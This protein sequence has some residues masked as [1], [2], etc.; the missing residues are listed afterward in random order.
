MIYYNYNTCIAVGESHEDCWF[1]WCQSGRLQGKVRIIKTLWLSQSHDHNNIILF[2]QS[3]P[4]PGS[5]TG[6]CCHTQNFH[7]IIVIIVLSI[8]PA[9]ILTS[10]LVCMAQGWLTSSSY[11][12]GQLPLKCKP[13]IDVV[14][15]MIQP[16]EPICNSHTLGPIVS[17]WS[18]WLLLICWVLQLG[19]WTKWLYN[20]LK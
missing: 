4:L 8:R 13:H 1:L 19:T 20:I 11:Q 12:T 5:I 2:F 9:I 14:I 6:Q 15:C 16:V 18:P 7:T 10:F 17:D 3:I